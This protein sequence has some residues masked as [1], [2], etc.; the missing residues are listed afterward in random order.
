[1]QRQASA[2]VAVDATIIAGF[3]GVGRTRTL[4]PCDTGLDEE[5]RSINIERWLDNH[6]V[7]IGDVLRYGR[8]KD[9]GHPRSMVCR[10]SGM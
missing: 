3:F 8:P 1:M 2:V 4:N 6:P 5:K 10:T 7:R 9:L